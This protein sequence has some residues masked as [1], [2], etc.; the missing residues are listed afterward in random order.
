MVF[1]MVGL[2]VVTVGRRYGRLKNDAPL[3]KALNAFIFGHP[4]SKQVQ[5]AL[6]TEYYARI[7]LTCTFGL[8]GSFLLWGILQERIMTH[9]YNTGKFESSNFLIFANRVFSCVVALICIH[10]EEPSEPMTAPLYIF[11][12]VSFS[13]VLSSWCQLEALKHVSFPTQVLGKSCKVVV[14][15]CV[16]V[17]FLKTKYSFSEY[18]FAFVLCSGMAVFFY[19]K[20]SNMEDHVTTATGAILMSMYI[21]FDACTAQWQ[22]SIFKT[23]SVS[24]SHMMLYVNFYSALFTLTSLISTGELY[25]SLEFIRLNNGFTVDLLLFSAASSIGLIFVFYTIK[26]LGV[27]TFVSLMSVRQIFAILI[28]SIIFDHHVGPVGLL[29]VCI[30]FG[31]CIVK[32]KLDSIET[33][34]QE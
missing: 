1:F 29:G 17:L 6:P 14:L 2:V 8:L 34:K 18:V 4:G 22:S 19:D 33:I 13:N 31:S 10:Y 28:S 16:G 20:K 25:P 26:H 27:F 30:V 7:L 23:Y 11:S 3:D 24:S 9:E 15:M 12:Y 32:M 21:F 5:T